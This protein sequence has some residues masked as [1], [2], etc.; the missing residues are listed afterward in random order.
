LRVAHLQGAL[1]RPAR[2]V[3]RPSRVAEV[4]A[5]L[6]EDRRHGERRE[7]VAPA[8]VVAV[9]RLQEPERGDLEQV[10]ERLRGT[11]VAAREAACERHGALHQGFAGCD[12]PV[13]LPANEQ[14]ARIL[15]AVGDSRRCRLRWRGD[16][17]RWHLSTPF[18][19]LSGSLLAAKLWPGRSRGLTGLYLL[20]AS[21][22]EV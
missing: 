13:A 19:W 20:R 11:S 18:H 8:R 1:L 3:Q 17:R 12:V 15:G 7:R 6:A 2:H 16:G 22:C 10:L 5:H 9:K 21:P 14:P 4:A